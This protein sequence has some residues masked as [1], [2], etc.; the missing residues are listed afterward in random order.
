[1]VNPVLERLYREGEVVHRSGKR[2]PINPPGIGPEKGEYLFRLVRDLRP[3]RTLEVG[4]AYGLS[5]LFIAEAL[6]RNGTGHHVVIDPKERTRFDGLGLRH[7]EEAGLLPWITFYEEPAELCLPRLVGENVRLDLAFDDSD[8]L[9]D[10]V[11]AEVL[12]LARLLREGGVL[13][14]DDTNLPGVGRACDFVATNRPDL[15]E[16][17][18]GSPPRG[19]LGA[20]GRRRAVP[21]PP[22]RMRVFEKVADRDTRDWKDFTPF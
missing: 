12:F 16:V 19:L 10:H 15:R 22:Q 9:F 5:T 18:A 6:R 4:F 1:V 21:A 20:L 14:L 2:K 7:V 11:I 13:V 8:H 3:A 17:V